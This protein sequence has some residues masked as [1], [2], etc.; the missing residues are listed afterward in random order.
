MTLRLEPD[1][2]QMAVHGFPGEPEN[3]ANLFVR[4]AVRNE[5]DHIDLATCQRTEL[6]IPPVTG[7]QCGVE[8]PPC[9][10]CFASRIQTRSPYRSS[11]DGQSGCQIRK[12]SAVW[13]AQPASA[14]RVSK[15]QQRGNEIGA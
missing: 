15:K 10:T 7:A 3:N 6:V 13:R 9:F 1:L 11:S 2:L 5:L 14:S 4:L 8:A 12:D